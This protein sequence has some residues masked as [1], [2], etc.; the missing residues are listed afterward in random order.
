MG[1]R[2]VNFDAEVSADGETLYAVDSRFSADGT[3]LTADLFMARRRDGAFE[4]TADSDN[5]LRLVNATDAPAVSSDGWSCSSRAST[6]FAPMPSR[7]S[8][9]PS[10]QRAGTVRRAAN[11]QRHFRLR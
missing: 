6:R 11:R 9:V 8:G 5:L 10:A 4:R 1:K 2:W 7:A 3:P